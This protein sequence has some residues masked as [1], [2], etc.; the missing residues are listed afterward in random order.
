MATTILHDLWNILNLFL[1]CAVITLTVIA[2]V[3]ISLRAGFYFKS[4][5]DPINTLK[6]EASLA[7]VY[8]QAREQ[9]EVSGNRL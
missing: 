6:K 8:D 4:F 3:I 9:E 7:T 1:V 2:N 5:R